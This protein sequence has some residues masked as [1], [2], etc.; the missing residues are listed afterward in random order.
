MMRP[1]SEKTDA[2]ALGA[3]FLEVLTGLP[4]WGGANG[5]GVSIVDRAIQDGVFV[6]TLLDSK[7]QWPPDEAKV[8][9]DRAVELT[10]FDPSRRSTVV[11]LE[12]K[13]EFKAHLERAEAPLIAG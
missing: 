2:F 12:Q 4:A 9:S 13:A 8:V 7:A 1:A 11:A 3:V 5:E 6:Q 10:C